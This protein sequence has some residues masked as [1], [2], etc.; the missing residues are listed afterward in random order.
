MA[1]TDEKNVS[2]N[3][4]SHGSSRTSE[5]PE[6]KCSNNV[7]SVVIETV[8][9]HEAFPTQV[10]PPIDQ[11]NPPDVVESL[12]KLDSKI[13]NV[14]DDDPFRHLPEHE[15]TILKRQTEV[16]EVK[17]G[18]LT[19]YRYATKMD[20]VILVVSAFCAIAAGAAMPLM[21]VST[22]LYGCC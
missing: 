18:Y 10:P 16:P 3:E 21:T 8:T 6:K 17:V 1:I 14:E 11:A 4:E 20:I 22:L 7:K 15:K 9:D 12:K 13:I 2:V 19:L 5:D